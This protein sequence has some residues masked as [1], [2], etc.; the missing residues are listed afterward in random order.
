MYKFIGLHINKGEIIVH[1]ML[2]KVI[3]F[4]DMINQKE[5]FLRISNLAASSIV[6]PLLCSTLGLDGSGNVNGATWLDILSGLDNLIRSD[7]GASVNSGDSR[8]LDGPD[9]S[10]CDCD[11]ARLDIILEVG[12]EHDALHLTGDCLN[13]GPHAFLCPCP[14]LCVDLCSE[15]NCL[16]HSSLSPGDKLLPCVY[17]CPCYSHKTGVDPCLDLCVYL[18]SGNHNLL[19]WHGLDLGADNRTE[20]SAGYKH[21][22]GR[23][24]TT[25]H[26]SSGDELG[27]NTCLTWDGLDD[28]SGH[29]TV[30]EVGAS[31]LPEL[32][33]DLSSWYI[34]GSELGLSI[35]NNLRTEPGLSLSN[36]N[37]LSWLSDGIYQILHLSPGYG[38]CHKLCA[39]NGV[40]LSSGHLNNP[41]NVNGHSSEVG[42]GDKYLREYRAWHNLGLNLDLCAGNYYIRTVGGTTGHYATSEYS[43]RRQSTTR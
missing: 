34:D 8:N 27:L 39:L 26:L 20:V 38:V 42:A 40:D 6:V 21:S 22:L 1:E 15:N 30:L 33:L 13:L 35:L 31:D 37:S 19:G 4:G 9:S 32:S 17:L 5:I 36:K 29:N 24:L 28:C 23:Q 2:N 16:R 14:E 18:C 7:D 11:E 12:R 10:V 43:S 25:L 41:G 3:D